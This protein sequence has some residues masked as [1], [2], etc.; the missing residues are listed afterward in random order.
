MVKNENSVCNAL[1]HLHHSAK[2]LKNTAEDWAS[3][4]A[5]SK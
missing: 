3:E 1:V 2:A 5:L 4:F